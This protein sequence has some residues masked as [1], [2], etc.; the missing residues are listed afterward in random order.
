VILG[1]LLALLATVA[2]G[3]GSVLES[4]GVRRAGA[5][6]GRAT[7]LIGLRRQP[8]YLLG[9]G[10]DLLGF[11]LA[12]IALH[13]LPL[14]LVQAMLAFSVGVTATIS[15]MLGTRL[16]A[17]GWTMLGVGAIGLGMLGV[18]AAPSPATA[19]PAIGS[20]VLLATPFLAVAIGGYA[21]HRD[22]SWTPHLLAFG[23]GL[24][25]CMV[26]VSARTLVSPEAV[27][28]LALQPSVWAL[29]LNGAAAAVLFALA[30]QHSAATT[31]TAIVFTT[32]TALSSLIGVV[33]L[34]DHV[35][36]GFTTVAAIGF[37]VA[38]AGAIGVALVSPRA[39][40]TSAIEPASSSVNAHRRSPDDRGREHRHDVGLAHRLPPTD[41]SGL[42]EATAALAA[43]T[44]RPTDGVRRR[45]LVATIKSAHRRVGGT[46]RRAHHPGG[47]GHPDRVRPQ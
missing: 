33:A 12:A 4:A 6:Q 23:A 37:A 38:I 9:I 7:D 44:E 18:S 28:Q 29:A 43:Q 15:A 34:D 1:Y 5:F 26:G 39:L 8:L 45:R 41:H 30:L 20:V 32:S 36:P 46:D 42:P 14:F 17:A 24:G 22:T 47:P 19:L 35:R 31:A 2:S 16:A 13:H 3:S 21:R 11:V 10:V 40:R 25:F 27:W